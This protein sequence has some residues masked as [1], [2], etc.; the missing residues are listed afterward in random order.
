VVEAPVNILT[1]NLY[2][3]AQG[4]LP[5]LV[6]CD[7]TLQPPKWVSP[8]HTIHNQAWEFVSTVDAWTLQESISQCTSLS[9]WFHQTDTSN[10][11]R[12]FHTANPETIAGHDPPTSDARYRPSS[13]T[14]QCHCLQ[15]LFF[16][17]YNFLCIPC[18]PTPNAPPNYL[19]RW[20]VQIMKFLI[21]H[22]LRPS[23]N[24]IVSLTSFWKAYAVA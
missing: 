4:N 15:F 5:A 20:R 18:L 1:D 24:Q 10:R 21:A 22:L 3:A 14:P 23:Y 13:V 7:N 9:A 2:A 16:L 19:P 17:H 12:R 8:V 6:Y 11:I